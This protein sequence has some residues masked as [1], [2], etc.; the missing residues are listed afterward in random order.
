MF[1]QDP[2][3]SDPSSLIPGVNY[4]ILST[5]AS[6]TRIS[7]VGSAPYVEPTT[8]QAKNNIRL[9]LDLAQQHSLHA[10]FHLDYNLDISSEPLIWFLL[11]ELQHMIRDGN[12]KCD[13]YVCIGHA[14]RLTLFSE[15]EWQRLASTINDNA[16]PVTFVGLPQ[17]DV[18]M[19]GRNA[20][21]PPRGTLN[22]VQIADKYGLDIAMAVNNV[23]NAFTPQGP[24][25]PLALCPLGVALFHAGTKDDCRTLVV[26]LNV[27][28]I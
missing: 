16:L 27:N 13:K 6:N 26:S 3:F 21:P 1:A 20:S 8:E 10:D 2:L 23:Q 7:S 18:Y 25:D 22:V 14:T 19:M 5:H 15:E 9:L 28:L 4:T 11:D 24:P 12:W 17:S